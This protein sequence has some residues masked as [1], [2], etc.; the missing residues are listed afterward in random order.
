MDA[1]CASMM[2][3]ASRGQTDEV[4]RLLAQGV[5]VNQQDDHG[6][7]ALHLAAWR[8]HVATADL[9]LRSG[10]DVNAQDLHGDTVLYLSAQQGSGSIV[11]LL[12]AHGADSTRANR[13]GLIPEQIAGGEAL[14][15]LVAHREQ[16]MLRAVA[17]VAVDEQPPA[18]RRM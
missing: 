9:L 3:A 10:G 13:Y 15:V 5:P 11:R 18:R 16:Q 2:L 1:I 7:T 14:D 12:L 4:A 17:G 6:H 8:A